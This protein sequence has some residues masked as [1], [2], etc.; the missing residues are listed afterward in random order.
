MYQRSYMSLAFKKMKVEV[1]LVIND[2]YMY[3]LEDTCIHNIYVGRGMV[4]SF[5]K[6]QSYYYKRVIICVS[7]SF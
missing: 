7:Q 4:I 3:K 6:K 1:Y 5:K 2:L